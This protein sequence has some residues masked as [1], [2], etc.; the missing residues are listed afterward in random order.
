MQRA[1]RFGLLLTLSLVWICAGAGPASAKEYKI[2]TAT[3]GGTYFPMASGAASLWSM[4]LGKKHGITVAA[5]ATA[6]SVENIELLRGKKADFAILQGHILRCAWRGV[7]Q[8]KGKPLKEI[9]SI[10]ALWP[11]VEHFVVRKDK[12]K[13]GTLEDL[14]GLKYYVGLKG[15]GTERST[16]TILAALGF[17]SKGFQRGKLDYYETARAIND[18]VLD[19]ASLPGGPPV[20][21]VSALFSAGTTEVVVLNVSKKEVKQIIEKTTY[22]GTAFVIKRTTYPGQKRAIKTISQPNILVARA[23]VPEEA[24]Y[25]LTKTLFENLAYMKQVHQM[26]KYLGLKSA[27][28]GV[29]APLHPGAYKY[30]KEKRLKIPAS[31]EP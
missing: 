5:Q 2:A 20:P 27:L 3:T 28:S 30:F 9:R 26:G 12:I 15:S 10:T 21:A 25:Q 18:G 11:D 29:S 16:E 17:D 7:E 19:G 23:D 24:V 13:K 14:K 31:L 1:T 4:T 8:Y 6:G 22:P